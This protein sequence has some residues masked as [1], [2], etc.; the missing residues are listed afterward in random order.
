M[1]PEE[2]IARKKAEEDARF[3]ADMEDR[4]AKEKALRQKRKAET[5][6]TKKR[7]QDEEEMQRRRHLQEE[8]RERAA[9]FSRQ[10]LGFNFPFP[11]D[12]LTAE[13]QK[14]MALI[15]L[16]LEQERIRKEA[17]IRVKEIDLRIEMMKLNR[18]RQVVEAIVKA[19]GNLRTA[20]QLAEIG[21][22]FEALDVLT[23][24]QLKEAR[25]MM[26]GIRTIDAFE[27]LIMRKVGYTNG[28]FQLLIIGNA[29]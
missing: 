5:M 19:I 16:K 26:L 10:S 22:I 9:Q 11:F 3:V 28:A 27:L 2:G 7:K 24:D 17:E 23:P 21:T 29:P 12:K 6:R 14:Q 13:Q 1:S 4:R 8:R 18:D 20:V 15:R 25:E